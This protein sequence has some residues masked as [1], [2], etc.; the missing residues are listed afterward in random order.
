[1]TMDML[2]RARLQEQGGQL[3]VHILTFRLWSQT[4]ISD[5]RHFMEVYERKEFVF[6]HDRGAG[7]CQ[8]LKLVSISTC[9]GCQ[10]EATDP[11][12]FVLQCRLQV[13]RDQKF[14]QRFAKT[15]KRLALSHAVETKL[16]K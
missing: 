12:V 8:C 10:L 6:I 4:L 13:L 9:A 2:C 16:S 14:A 15:K 1:M 5:S 11:P 7:M 3:F